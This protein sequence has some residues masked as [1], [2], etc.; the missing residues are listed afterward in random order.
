MAIGRLFYE[1]DGDTS[2]LNLAL[3]EAIKNTEDA[4]VRMTRAGQSIISKFDE[5]LNPTKKLSEQIHGCRQVERGHLES[6][7]R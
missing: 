7:V 6:H 4:G 2:K 5:T 3:Q 1:I